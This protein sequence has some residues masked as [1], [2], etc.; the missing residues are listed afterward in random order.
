MY[1]CEHGPF[2][3]DSRAKNAWLR[4]FPSLMSQK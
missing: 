3:F 2:E 4:L 1:G